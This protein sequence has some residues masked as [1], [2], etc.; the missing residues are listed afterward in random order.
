[1]YEIAL[2]AIFILLTIISIVVSLRLVMVSSGE[3][4]IYGLNMISLGYFFNLFPNSIGSLLVLLGLAHKHYA[5]RNL[6][7][8][9]LNLLVWILCL[10]TPV[11]LLSVMSVIGCAFKVSKLY[12]KFLKKPFSFPRSKS[13]I[14]IIFLIFTGI[15]VLSSFYVFK[16][17]GGIPLLK[18]FYM[19]SYEMEVF[20]YLA[21]FK[22]SGNP[23]IK[24]FTGISLSVILSYI[25][26]VYFQ[27][28]EK[29]LFVVLIWLIN[30]TMAIFLLT[31]D[32]E[33]LHLIF[34]FLGYFL[35]YSLLH[36]D[37]LKKI[38][39]ETIIVL[40][41]VAFLLSFLTF[42]YKSFSYIFSINGPFGRFFISQIVPLYYHLIYFPKIHPFLYGAYYP[43]FIAEMFGHESIRSSKIVMN[44]FSSNIYAGY[45]NTIF[46]AEAY[47]NWGWFGIF[48]SYFVVGF[49]YEIIYIFFLKLPKNPITLSIF[50][51]NS[52]EFVKIING[53]FYDFI[54]NPGFFFSLLLLVVFD[55]YYTKQKSRSNA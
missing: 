8:F 27:K 50:V 32:Y 7:D 22:F 21:K 55:L 15:V 18:S 14:K 46:I 9:K 44:I 13:L 30:S 43:K 38:L 19:T 25:C 20:R 6:T 42:Q 39:I 35:L 11:I 41:I 17:L 10:I 54:Y 53:G 31:Y 1:M 52:I 51:Y 23:Y 37:V 5:A 40:V 49:V 4:S 45:M 34:Y 33:K 48:F 12:K 28:I 3:K 16:K 2:K 36:R 29:S 26:F 24:N 47:A